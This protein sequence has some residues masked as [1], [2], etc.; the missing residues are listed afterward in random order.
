MSTVGPSLHYSE[1]GQQIE[2]PYLN[3][4]VQQN[5]GVVVVKREVL[6]IESDFAKLIVHMYV[7]VISS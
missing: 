2:G 5:I 1:R 7:S 4:N 6:K 3:A